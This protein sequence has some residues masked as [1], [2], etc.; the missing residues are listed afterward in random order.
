MRGS[1]P[2]CLPDW[3]PP[4]TPSSSLADG[5]RPKLDVPEARDQRGLLDFFGSIGISW[6]ARMAPGGARIERL[7]LGKN[8][9]KNQFRKKSTNINTNKNESSFP[10]CLLAV[11]GRCAGPLHSQDRG[12]VYEGSAGQRAGARGLVDGGLVTQTSAAL[13]ALLGPGRPL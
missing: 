3:L 11:P 2:A 6:D 13:L 9:R 8:L 5:R 4:G 7:F 12:P 1:N 10:V